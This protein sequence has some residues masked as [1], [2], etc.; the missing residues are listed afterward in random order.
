MERNG[1]SSG[2]TSSH[3]LLYKNA[4]RGIF[5]MNN[6]FRGIRKEKIKE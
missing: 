5:I 3:A 2:N 4:H 1:I 6:V